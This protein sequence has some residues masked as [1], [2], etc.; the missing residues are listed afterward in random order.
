MQSSVL[1]KY[2][3]TNFFLKMI[4]GLYILSFI[5]YYYKIIVPKSISSVY[6]NRQCFDLSVNLAYIHSENL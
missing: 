3:G 1:L 5:G 2:K 4:L 6:F